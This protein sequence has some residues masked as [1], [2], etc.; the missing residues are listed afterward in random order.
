MA[1]LYNDVVWEGTS[2]DMNSPE[3]EASAVNGHFFK[4]LDTGE[5]YIRKLGAWSHLEA[6]L[7]F[8]KA[9]KSGLTITDATGHAHVVFATPVI[10]LQFSIALACRLPVGTPQP[11]PAAYVLA[12]DVDGFDLVTYNVRNNSLLGN[13]V[14]SWVMT[15]DYNPAIP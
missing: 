13:V 11:L 5:S 10:N 8:V 12:Q 14:V 6:G 4:Q 3:V 9:T 2:A 1:I 7:S 15:L